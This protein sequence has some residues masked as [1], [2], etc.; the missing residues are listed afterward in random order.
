[1]K[2]EFKKWWSDRSQR[3]EKETTMGLGR[4]NYHTEAAWKA[5]WDRQQLKIDELVEAA[6][7]MSEFAEDLLASNRGYIERIYQVPLPITHYDN[8]K[9]KWLTHIKLETAIKEANGE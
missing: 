1:M 3:I 6:E 8:W 2:D 9:N 5:A 7:A 4:P